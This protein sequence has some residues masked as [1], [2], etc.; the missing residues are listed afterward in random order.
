MGLGAPRAWRNQSVF[1]SADAPWPIR[2]DEAMLEQMLLMEQ[3]VAQAQ[4]EAR[5]QVVVA[6]D[7]LEIQS[8]EAQRAF[9]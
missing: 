4:T 5:A 2:C 7:I 3:R 1:V 9:E 8:L 6:A